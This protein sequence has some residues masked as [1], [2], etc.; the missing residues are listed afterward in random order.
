MDPG[1]KAGMT[2][3]EADRLTRKKP[4]L[5][6]HPAFD[7]ASRAPTNA[8]IRTL[9]VSHCPHP[10]C[11]PGPRAGTHTVIATNRE[12]RACRDLI[13]GPGSPLRSAR[14]DSERKPIG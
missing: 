11:H 14:D 13:M 9:V 8:S 1:S 3:E 6:R 12:C 4:A 7:A 5:P 2:Q 10:R